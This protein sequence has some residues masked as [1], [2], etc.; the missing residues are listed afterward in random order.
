MLSLDA[1]VVNSNHIRMDKPS[2]SA[3]LSME[4][5]QHLSLF[6]EVRPN[7]FYSD[8]PFKR[9]IDTG[10]HRTHAPA[11]DTPLQP[12]TFRK[13]SRH[14]HTNQRGT[15]IGTHRLTCVETPSTFCA[16]LKALPVWSSRCG[17]C[18]QQREVRRDCRKQPFILAT[19]WFL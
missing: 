10:I 4:S 6:N 13:D 17:A 1:E 19:I 18:R 16:F 12:V 14:V 3:S 7:H 11:A 9:F 15:I 5:R 2:C 8:R